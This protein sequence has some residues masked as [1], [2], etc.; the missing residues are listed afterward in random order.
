MPRMGG[1]LEDIAAVVREGDEKTTAQLVRAALAE[2][3]DAQVILAD[4]LVPGLQ[5][6]GDL[7]KNGRAFLPEIFIS[8]RA[9]KAGLRE[10][11][12]LERRPRERS[13][14]VILGSVEGDLHD[15][16]RNLVGM[17]L[18]GN[19]FNVIDLGGDVP[20]DKFVQA[21]EDNKADIVAL[22]SL[23]TTTLPEFDRVARALEA[24]GVR[25]N[26][27]VLVGG[28]PASRSLADKVGAEGFAEDCVAAVDEA[29]RL[30]EE[31]GRR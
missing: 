19:G 26:V 22:S 17:M 31:R 7:F 5:Q 30:I 14:T 29:R 9:F 27:N 4:G 20:A 3:L 8:V 18:Q 12:E 15:I 28:A 25:A 23:L 1:G 10:L 6:L 24:A 2:G 13:G 21:A 16:G 11:P